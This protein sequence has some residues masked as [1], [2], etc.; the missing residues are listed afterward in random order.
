MRNDNLKL[1]IK[2]Y[3]EII[4]RVMIDINPNYAEAYNDLGNLLLWY[5]KEEEGMREIR[6]AIEIN[7]N[8]I[9][10]HQSLA[11]RLHLEGRYKEEGQ[12]RKKIQEISINLEQYQH[13]VPMYDARIESIYRRIGYYGEWECKFMDENL[14]T[15]LIEKQAKIRLLAKSFEQSNGKN[16]DLLWEK[17]PLS[18]QLI[19]H[20]IITIPLTLIKI[21][22]K[23]F[24]SAMDPGL[25]LANE[26]PKIK[27]EIKERNKMR[28]EILER[29]PSQKMQ[30]SID[31]NISHSSQVPRNEF[32][33]LLNEVISKMRN[34]E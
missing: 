21:V 8:L 20:A 16:H 26:L 13:E 25:L 18:L 3:W 31:K 4:L 2:D 9:E 1:T 30:S 27:A 10:A 17:W 29:L 19:L 5:G 14:L 11:G 22:A 23:I 28:K 7:P 6:K 24:N 15:Q 12:E 32:E 34:G 33:Q